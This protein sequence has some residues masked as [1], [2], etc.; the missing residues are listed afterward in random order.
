MSDVA[1]LDAEPYKPRSK[2]K[3]LTAALVLALACTGFASTFLGF[4]DPGKLMP[5]KKAEEAVEAPTFVF[6]DVP[7]IVLTLAGPRPRTLVLSAKIEADTAYEKNIQYLV[8]RIS[9][10]FNL[11]LSDVDPVAFERRGI[12]DI[13]RSELSTRLSYILGPDSF[14]DL[15][16]TEFRIQ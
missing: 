9:D 5:G 15:L 14:R 12:L 1:E 11:F 8:P 16:I 13:I 10:S 6:I 7:Q 3:L 2:A 4:L